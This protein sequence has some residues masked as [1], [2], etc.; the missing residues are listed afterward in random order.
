MALPEFTKDSR[1][2][3][4]LF[5]RVSLF[6]KKKIYIYINLEILVFHASILIYILVYSCLVLQRALVIDSNMSSL[7]VK[8]NQLL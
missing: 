2:N 3:F 7:P 8:A 1:Q 6:K 4:I 5:T